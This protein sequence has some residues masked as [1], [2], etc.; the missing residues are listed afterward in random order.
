MELTEIVEGSKPLLG[1]A[2][3]YIGTHAAVG[4][5]RGMIRYAKASH[6]YENI[7]FMKCAAKKSIESRSFAISA[8]VSVP[9]YTIIDCLIRQ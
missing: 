6:Y 9:A 5:I 2:G 1:L 3:A 4:L 8:L 7:S